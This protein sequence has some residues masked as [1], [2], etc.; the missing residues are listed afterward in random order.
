MRLRS[1]KALPKMTRP[2][3]DK[4]NPYNNPQNVVEKPVGSTVGNVV[5]STHVRTTTHVAASKPVSS[6]LT[7]GE[8]PPP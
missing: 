6:V 3:M 8:I 5:I 1:G 7:Q 4:P 2:P